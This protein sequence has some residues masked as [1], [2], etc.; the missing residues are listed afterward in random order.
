MK[1]FDFVRLLRGM[2]PVASVSSQHTFVK[3]YSNSLHSDSFILL[4]LS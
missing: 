4:S 2:M 1:S 3:R